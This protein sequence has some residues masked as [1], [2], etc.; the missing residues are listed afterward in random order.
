MMKLVRKIKIFLGRRANSKLALLF[1]LPLFGSVLETMG[2]STIV[3]FISMIMDENAFESNKYLKAVYVWT[4]FESIQQFVVAVAIALI[5]FYIFKTVYLIGEYYIQNRLVKD[6]QQNLSAKL[7]HIILEKPYEYFANINLAEIT[8]IVGEDV[9]RTGD[10]ILNMMQLFSELLTAAMLI[11]MLMVIDFKMTFLIC[12]FLLLCM[13][14]IRFETKR[15]LK[16][17]GKKQQQNL[18]ERQK[19]LNQSVYGIKDIKISDNQEYFEKKFNTANLSWNNTEIVYSMWN[20]APSYLIEFV[21]MMT[22]LI[23][24]IIIILSGNSITSMITTLSAFAFSAVR[25]LPA[26]NR[27]SS[28]LTT[29]SYRQQSFNLVY[30]LITEDNDTEKQKKKESSE[31]FKTLSEGIECLDF[32]FQYENADKKVFENTS[33]SIPKGKSVGVIGPSG[34]GKTTVVDILLGL[35]KPQKGIV[36][37]DHKDIEECYEDY[38]AKISY[39]P[40]NIFLIDDTIRNNV[41]FGID[42]SN[43]S[44]ERVWKVLEEAQIKEYV[45]SLPEGI[46]TVVGER[47][48]RI[49]GGQRQRIGIARAL[50]NNPEILVFDEATSALDNET[51]AAIMESINYF[52]GKKTMIIIA[53][54]LSTIENCDIVYKVENQK[55][56]QVR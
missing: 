7:L 8:R 19:W 48:I 55:V 16:T 14:L 34:A 39:I 52:K 29:M 33:I 30:E 50:Y 17:A 23:Y 43:I 6:T 51:E 38:L 21:I 37:V 47:G 4:G 28:Y 27:I 53:H 15:K 20:K 32:S 41:A 42:E 12:T 1:F 44:E 13:L 26:C 40:Q 22:I 31:N 45:E 11:G 24:L 35:L 2:I 9:Q 56:E 18:K 25:L 10:Y 3:A 54:R 36:R 5:I 49:S 46:E